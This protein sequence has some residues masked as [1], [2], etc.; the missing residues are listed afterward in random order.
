[1]EKTNFSNLISR[2]KEEEKNVSP[3]T[4]YKYIQFKNQQVLFNTWE[5]KLGVLS[6]KA[7]Q[8]YLKC[9]SVWSTQIC[10]E[11]ACYDWLYLKATGK[12]REREREGGG[13]CAPEIQA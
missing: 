6:V 12:G 1:M 9:N 10:K 3:N 13:I 2:V 5:I 4:T 7:S 11:D 8:L